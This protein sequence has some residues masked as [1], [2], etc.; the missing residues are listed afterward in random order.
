MVKEGD[1]AKEDL[2]RSIASPDGTE[3]SWVQVRKENTVLRGF[4]DDN[5]SLDLSDSTGNDSF[6]SHEEFSSLK[7]EPPHAIKEWHAILGDKHCGNKGRSTVAT[8]IIKQVKKE[9]KLSH[10]G[11]R[12]KDWQD[13]AHN[14]YKDR[15]AK[16]FSHICSPDIGLVLVHCTEK[17]VESGRIHQSNVNTYA[18]PDYEAEYGPA[19]TGKAL[20]FFFKSND[21]PTL[22]EKVT[23]YRESL[24]VLR[25][26][27]ERPPSR[28]MDAF[29]NLLAFIK[30]R[31]NAPEDDIMTKELLE[32]TKFIP[33]LDRQWKLLNQYKQE[34]PPAADDSPRS[35]E[36]MEEA[37]RRS[38]QV[39]D[40]LSVAQDNSDDC[41]YSHL[42]K[43]EVGVGQ[44]ENN[45][46]DHEIRRRTEAGAGDGE[47]EDSGDVMA[48]L[49]SLSE[50]DQGRD[51][52]LQDDRIDRLLDTET[53][54]AELS[55]QGKEISSADI[56]SSEPDSPP[57]ALDGTCYTPN[58][59]M[60]GA[61]STTKTDGQL[62]VK[63]NDDSSLEC[64]PARITGGSTPDGKP[65]TKSV[66][67]KST[68][69]DW[70]N[71]W[72]IPRCCCIWKSC[73][74][75]QKEFKGHPTL[76]GV[77]QFKFAANDSRAMMLKSS[78][79]RNL[80][81][82]VSKANDWKRDKETD[83]EMVKYYVA[84]HHWTEHHI[85]AYRA[86]PL[87]RFFFEPFSL[88]DA[89]K[90]LPIVLSKET[91]CDPETNELMY[92][93]APLV[94]KEKVKE[95]VYSHKHKN[96][97][98]EK[99][100]NDSTSAPT[101]RSK[102]HSH[103]P[104]LEVENKHLKGQ[105][106]KL[107]SDLVYLQDLVKNL[108]NE[109]S[110]ERIPRHGV[111]F[112][113]TSPS[114]DHSL[115]TKGK[116]TASC[117]R[118]SQ[119]SCSHLVRLDGEKDQVAAKNIQ[120]EQTKEDRR[121]FTSFLPREI[122]LSN[123]SDDADI[124]GD[125][126]EWDDLP[127]FFDGDTLDDDLYR[128]DDCSVASGTKRRRGDLEEPDESDNRS[129]TSSKRGRSSRGSSVGRPSDKGAA[130]P[131]IGDYDGASSVGGVYRVKAQEITDPY[132]E[133]G[134][135][136]G[137]ISISSGMPHGF[138]HFE[139]DQ[140]GRWYKGDWKHGRWTGQ[141][142]LCNGGGDYYEGGLKNDHKHGR[143]VMRF[144]DGRIF[145]GEYVN[146][147]MVE[148]KMIYQD[149][150]TYSGSWVNGMRH[151][152]GRCVFTDNSVYEGEL[153]EG[154]FFGHGKMAWSDGGWYEGE[155]YNGEMQG[156][157]KE[158]RPDGSLRHEGQWVKGQPVR[159]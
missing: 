137:S 115:D 68:M 38:N 30:D 135:Y 60:P 71:D 103:V 127:S 107:Q 78:I 1:S 153:K 67:I 81:V 138:G 17:V 3:G 66:E 35:G 112:E 65:T 154:E 43:V 49:R 94:T 85:R 149:G 97:N 136:T 142:R 122:S 46:T 141:G 96:S 111:A 128:N 26:S 79:D 143:G 39:T 86:D 82:T 64:A 80:K 88:S 18:Y 145:E 150:S 47:T 73:R 56:A 129:S 45:G 108:Q 19:E 100:R 121:D 28:M 62:F 125:G 72:T 54:D 90:Y 16:R 132:G 7:N 95:K 34:H 2:P 48:I 37:Q 156:F 13:E 61:G 59:G 110:N 84:C 44:N 117:Q 75:Y 41:K 116:R 144:A 134:I 120:S 22:T 109:L 23:R 101:N 11:K 42:L 92:L 113:S 139:Y 53:V 70:K 93:Q 131:S 21:A 106:L 50:T 98:E 10:S 51:L 36:Y 14:E 158:V 114:C 25:N 119:S 102:R 29:E 57:R 8:D 123:P 15:V 6:S 155:F 152:H 27:P 40:V 89:S 105:V 147:Q 151:G 87:T 52:S 157:G 58:Y 159:K 74:V 63:L 77:L 33:V 32:N 76:G 31:L 55:N 83:Q 140:A 4:K 124:E 9:F 99:N 69:Q 104:D 130:N 12:V 126:W 133:H 146:G 91:F 5:K 148:G 118:S 24:C 20:H